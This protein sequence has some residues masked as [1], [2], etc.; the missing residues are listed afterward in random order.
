MLRQKNSFLFQWQSAVSSARQLLQQNSNGSTIVWCACELGYVGQQRPSVKSQSQRSLM[1]MQLDILVDIPG[2][3]A[4]GIGMRNLMSAVDSESTP[5]AT[6][7]ARDCF[8]AL[9]G[10]IW[11]S[12]SA[13]SFFSYSANS[14]H[15]TE[16]QVSQPCLLRSRALSQRFFSLMTLEPM[17]R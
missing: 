16:Q 3:R 14:Y 17:K 13:T 8:L 1:I 15:R 9:C 11:L 5:I 12:V 7:L 10:P 6:P 2:R 4:V